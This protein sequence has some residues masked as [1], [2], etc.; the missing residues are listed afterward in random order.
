MNNI[1]YCLL[2][3]LNYKG[4]YY[5]AYGKKNNM[6]AMAILV[7]N[8]GDQ[9]K[10]IVMVRFLKMVKEEGFFLVGYFSFIYQGPHKK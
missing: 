6:P 2:R 5:Q 10:N 8:G 7:D 4:Y 9:N 3:W 1:V